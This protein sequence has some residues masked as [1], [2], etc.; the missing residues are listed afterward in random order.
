MLFLITYKF[1]D[2]TAQESGTK[3]ITEWYDKEGPQSRPDGYE[4]NSWIFL[5]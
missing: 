5:P 2:A 1:F 4:V 3:M